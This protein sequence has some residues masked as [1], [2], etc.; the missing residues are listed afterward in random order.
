M[1][2]PRSLWFALLA[3]ALLTF[4][5][6]SKPSHADKISAHND[7]EFDSWIADHQDVL[8]T[9]EVHGLNEA[10]QLLK[11][12]VMTQH[13]GLTADQAA[14]A[15]YQEIDGQTANGVLITG[16][17]LKIDAAETKLAD[18]A[19]MVAKYKAYDQ[20]KFLND[21]QHADVKNKLRQLDEKVSAQQTELAA[22]K[23]QLADLEAAG[24]G[25]AGT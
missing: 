13:P 4:S 10:R 24:G 19:P 15:L 8:S 11:F 6:C 23:K 17:K 22:L 14:A 21:E 16:C 12:K 1:M 5:A 3:G 2:S 25:N 7:A 9:D 20:D 18:F